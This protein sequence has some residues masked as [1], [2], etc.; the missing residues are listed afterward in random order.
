VHAGS[1][2]LPLG[3]LLRGGE[4]GPPRH[5]S[6]TTARS[7]TRAKRS[8]STRRSGCE[9]EIERGRPWQP[10]VETAFNV[11][12]SMADSHFARAQSW[13]RCTLGGSRGLPTN[14]TTEHT[15]SVSTADVRSPKFS[16]M[17][18]EGALP[19]GEPSSLLAVHVLHCIREAQFSIVAADRFC[20]SLSQTL[21]RTLFFS[22]G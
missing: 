3:A 13:S 21:C 9:E 1:D 18:L 19:R 10:Y 17:A 5:S 12:R 14:R 15:K 8:R 2:L 4:V 7:S 20:C 11:Q 22:T 6:P 16:R